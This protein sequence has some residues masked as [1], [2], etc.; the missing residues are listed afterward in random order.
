MVGE[1][2]DVFETPGGAFITNLGPRTDYGV[3]RTLL[4]T[5]RRSDGWLEV[6]LPMRPNGSSGWIRADRVTLT[7]TGYEIRVLTGEHRLDLLNAGAVVASSPVV[8]GAPSTPTPYGVFYVTDPVDLRSSPGNPYGAFAL[9]TSGYSNVHFQFAGGP[10][11]IAVHGTPNPELMG[12]NVSNGCIR[13]PD[14]FILHLAY[15]VP[16]G[17]PVRII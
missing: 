3:V 7:S 15:T 6:L 14:D 2:I 13:V 16:L 5:Q 9:G 17:T 11:Q 10:G 8:L 1:P 12:Q 4:V